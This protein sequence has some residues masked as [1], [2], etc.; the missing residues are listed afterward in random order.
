MVLTP[1]CFMIQDNVRCKR[2]RRRVPEFECMRKYVDANALRQKYTP[3]FA[4]PQGAELRN[5]YGKS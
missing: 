4:C 3:C 2:M 1:K 5:S